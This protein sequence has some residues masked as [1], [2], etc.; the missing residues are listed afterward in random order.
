MSKFS[1]DCVAV[2]SHIYVQKQRQREASRTATVT[3]PVTG[4]CGVKNYRCVQ[5]QANKFKI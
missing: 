4:L 1:A 5:R 3:Y 2:F